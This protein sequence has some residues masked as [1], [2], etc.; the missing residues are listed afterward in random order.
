MGVLAVLD[1][2]NA[3]HPW[4][5]NDAYARYVLK[6]ARAVRRRGGT[7]ALDVGC[8]TGNLLERLSAVFPTVFGIEPDPEAAKIAGQRFSD[9]PVSIEQRE[10]GGE[11]ESYDVIVFVASLHHMS[12]RSALDEARRA[13]RAGGRIVIVGVAAET[14][15]D[16]FRSWAS[17]LLNPFVGLI[18]HPSRATEPPTHMQVPTAPAVQSF[19]EIR[20]IAADVLPGI[21]MRRRLFWR[22][23][24]VWR[25]P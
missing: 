25:A 12:L 16:R 21:R 6:H 7:T 10:L 9:T 17:A 15:D 4:S 1:R 8:G 18:L 5:H 13:L 23:T 22:Y 20:T 19:D 2:V 11:T 3:A 24:A 14:V